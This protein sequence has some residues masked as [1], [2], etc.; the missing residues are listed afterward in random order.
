M[1]TMLFWLNHHSRTAW[2]ELRFRTAC[3]WLN[4]RVEF[5]AW[6]LR[7]SAVP[8][9]TDTMDHRPHRTPMFQMF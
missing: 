2:R 3:W 4:E 9:S 6:R 8:S 7:A 1:K 5:A